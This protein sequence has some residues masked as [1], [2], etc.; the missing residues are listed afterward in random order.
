MSSHVH[1]CDEVDAEAAWDAGYD[2]GRHDLEAPPLSEA[3][4]PLDVER[5]ARALPDWM[6]EHPM[7]M[8]EE[9]L[10]L[11]IAANIAREYAKESQP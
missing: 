7:G 1:C 8:N 11:V 3:P 9:S 10:R 4:A 5:L 2:A 6:V